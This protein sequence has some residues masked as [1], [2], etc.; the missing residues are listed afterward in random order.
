MAKTIKTKTISVSQKHG[1]FSTI[2]HRFG[3]SKKKELSEIA[4]LRMLLS[5]EKARI[6][7]IVKTKQPNS[8]YGLAKLLGRDYK[9]VRQDLT[10]LEKYGF[11]DM[12][13]IHKGKRET[14]KPVLA[15]DELQITIEL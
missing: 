12:I 7:H 1:A 13:P 9:S 2:F 8:L 15:L 5:N 3:K 6:L 11:I 10:V 14:L 4:L